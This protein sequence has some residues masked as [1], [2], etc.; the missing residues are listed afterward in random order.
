MSIGRT[1]E[2]DTFWEDLDFFD[3][4]G[5]VMFAAAAGAKKAADVVW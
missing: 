3:F 1:F 4:V 2:I 5:R